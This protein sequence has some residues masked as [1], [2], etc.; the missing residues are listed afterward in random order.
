MATD[1][2]SRQETSTDEKWIP[3]TCGMCVYGGCATRAHVVDG[4]LTKIEGNPE[5]LHN[6]GRLC[7]RGNAV[8]MDLYD[9]YRVKVPM[10][11]TNPEKGLDVDPK[12]VEI[13]WE[14]AL[15][16]VVEKL[17]AVRDEDPRGFF[18]NGGL[19]SGSPGVLG[20]Q[21]LFGS[22]HNIH[23]LGGQGA[24]GNAEHSVS[25][26]THFAGLSGWDPEYTDL[27]IQ[28]GGGAGFG[29]WLGGAGCGVQRM[30][31]ARVERGMRVV[32]IDPRCSE[33]G[34]KAN[35]W[36]PIVPGTD[37]A[38][39]LAMMHVMLH[40]L[41]QY[42]VELLKRHTNG[43]YLIR[44]D[45]YYMKDS[46]KPEKPLVWDT[47]A[48][49]A[50][51]W[52][53]VEPNDVALEGVYEVNGEPCRPALQMVKDRMVPYTPEWQEPITTVPAATIRKLAADF[54]T[55][56]KIGATITLDG[57]EFPY[58][59]V[60]IIG[61]HG[62]NRHMNS[63]FN[64][65][66]FN[67]INALVGSYDVPGG[68]TGWPVNELGLPFDPYNMPPPA[69]GVLELVPWAEVGGTPTDMDLHQLYPMTWDAAANPKWTLTDPE[70]REKFKIPYT[71][72]VMLQSAGNPFRSMGDPRQTE[73]AYQAIEFI[74]SH[75]LWIDDPT[76][77]A[78]VVLPSPGKLEGLGIQQYLWLWRI[79]VEGT[80]I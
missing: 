56:A 33:G 53:E 28:V 30:A 58:R 34:N 26:W 15:D 24:C 51:P 6:L 17:K 20:F 77:F 29:S 25:A 40:E 73:K 75:A 27:F 23:Y 5:A 19:S 60:S 67:L 63:P 79:S 11:R 14:E 78:D 74:V 21:K 48:Q 46:E 7:P 35:Q 12:F 71:F 76:L 38:L 42:D 9:P 45:G 72:K 18:I 50:R 32:I 80:M 64:V 65:M 31:D 39:F 16:I 43:P 55:S 52:D 54:V 70:L 36:I 10:K 2:T 41:N 1:T 62:L 57:I 68:N 37:L 47:A 13:T 3:T 49:E 69:D 8:I 44:P 59:P 22:T 66:A 4:V 61:Y